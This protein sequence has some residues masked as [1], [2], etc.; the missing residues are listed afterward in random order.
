MLISYSLSSKILNR[1]LIAA[2]NC[3]RLT[4]LLIQYSDGQR[5]LTFVLMKWTE[6]LYSP[7]LWTVNW[8]RY[9]YFLQQIFPLKQ[10]ETDLNSE[11]LG[12]DYY[13]FSNLNKLT[14]PPWNT[15][16]QFENRTGIWRVHL[17]EGGRYIGG[18]GGDVAVGGS[19]ERRPWHA[20]VTSNKGS[21]EPI[22]FMI[23]RVLFVT[24]M[25]LKLYTEL[26]KW[27]RIL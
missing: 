17:T 3:P 11:K 7:M 13:V 25:A 1:T 15:G 12:L 21:N 19:G 2:S 9:S 5:V 24:S 4:T 22:Q 20:V 10:S 8:S 14:G 18:N 6:L 26:I 23:D 27:T 16:G